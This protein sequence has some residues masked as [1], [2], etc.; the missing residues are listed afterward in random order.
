MLEWQSN[1]DLCDTS[2]VLYQLTFQGNLEPVTLK[3]YNIPV[4]GEEM[5]VNI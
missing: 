4:N 5:Q 3:V 2:A 1:H